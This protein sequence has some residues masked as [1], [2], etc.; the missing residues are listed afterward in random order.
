MSAL[1]AAS[2]GKA[3]IQVLFPLEMIYTFASFAACRV[4]AVGLNS[5]GV[6]YFETCVWRYK[7]QDFNLQSLKISRHKISQKVLRGEVTCTCLKLSSGCY[8]EEK[9][10]MKMFFH[11]VIV[12]CGL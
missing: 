2:R 9:L 3:S 8:G 1:P 10:P 7:N 11:L 12:L 4:W 5:A 6:L